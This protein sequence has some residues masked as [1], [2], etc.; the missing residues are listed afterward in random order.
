MFLSNIGKYFLSISLG[1]HKEIKTP[2][3]Q[4]KGH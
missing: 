4:H 3:I 1:L 2:A